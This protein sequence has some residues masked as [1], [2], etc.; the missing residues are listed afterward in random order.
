MASI[1]CDGDAQSRAIIVRTAPALLIHDRQ[2][3]L[4]EDNTE[5]ANALAIHAAPRLSAGRRETINLGDQFIFQ[6]DVTIISTAP[7][8]GAD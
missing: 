1:S 4:S 6:R 7:C 8:S 2:L 5:R 3:S